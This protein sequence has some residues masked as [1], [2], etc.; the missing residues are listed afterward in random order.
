[1][2]VFLRWGIFGIVVVAALLY[3]YNASKS[4]VARRDPGVT[5]EV[6][7]VVSP[8]EP[9]AEGDAEEP[10]AVETDEAQPEAVASGPDAFPEMPAFCEEERLVAERALKFRRCS[11]R[12]APAP[13]PG[14]VPATASVWR[15]W[16]ASMR[17]RR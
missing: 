9:D 3:A 10:E 13:A 14:R 8:R 16:S 4:L 7:Q 6:G 17:R 12:R 2:G 1:M 15:T 5:Q 11:N